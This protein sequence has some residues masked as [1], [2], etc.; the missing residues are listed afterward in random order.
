[1]LQDWVPSRGSVDDDVKVETKPLTRNMPM[2]VRD[3][4]ACCRGLGEYKVRERNAELPAFLQDCP[5]ND[6]QSRIPRPCAR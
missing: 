1:M 3:V 5:L 4:F 2:G 6:T